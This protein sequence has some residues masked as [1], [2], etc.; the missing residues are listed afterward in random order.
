MKKRNNKEQARGNPPHISA[1][2]IFY[3]EQIHYLIFGFIYF[4]ACA[5]HL[6]QPASPEIVFW[7]GDRGQSPAVNMHL[8]WEAWWENT[9]PLP[10][11]LHLK[12]VA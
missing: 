1:S 2:F 9:F 7:Q 8:L 3:W 10:F 6:V 12:P 5:M 11:I 4:S